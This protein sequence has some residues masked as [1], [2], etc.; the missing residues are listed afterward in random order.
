MNFKTFKRTNPSIFSEIQREWDLNKGTSKMNLIVSGSIYSLM[1]QIFEDRKEPLFSRAGQMIH[2]KP[3]EVE[4][5]KV[6]ISRS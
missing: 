2:L 6:D 4:V 3:F 1:H 5:L